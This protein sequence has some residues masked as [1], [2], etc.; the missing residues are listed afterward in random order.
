MLK[1]C[2]ECSNVGDL[3]GVSIL[4]CCGPTERRHCLK[5]DR[6]VF[7]TKAVRCEFY[8]PKGESEGILTEEDR[9]E[10]S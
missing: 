4:S 7:G 8:L 5:Q 2:R 1:R 6:I 10:A 9:E 3:I